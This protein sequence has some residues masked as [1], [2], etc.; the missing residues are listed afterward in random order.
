MAGNKHHIRPT[1]GHACRHRTHADLRHELDADTRL[2]VSIAEVEDEL[3]QILDGINIM[4]RRRRNKRNTRRRVTHARDFLIHLTAGKLATLTGLCPLRHL[5]LQLARIRQILRRHPETPGGNLLD[6]RARVVPILSNRVARGVLTALAAV[7]HSPDAVHGDSNHLVRLAGNGTETHGPGNETAHDALLAL[8][9]IQGDGFGL[10][11]AEEPAQRA[12]RLRTLVHHLGKDLELRVIPVAQGLLEL[13]NDTGC[14][15]MLLPAALPFIQ[16]GIFRC[17]LRIEAQ[18][19]L[20]I[21]PR[22]RLPTD[23]RQPDTTDARC[24]AGEISVHHLITQTDCLEDLRTT[25][26]TQGGNTHLGHRLEQTEVHRFKIIFRCLGSR[27]IFCQ[28][29][30][31]RQ[32]H[33]GAEGQ[34]R[35]HRRG[36]VAQQQGKVH[37]LTRLTRLR[38]HAGTGSHAHLT[39]L[40]VH[41]SHG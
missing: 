39:Q 4:M 37:H 20:L 15:D 23:F 31:L 13:G 14:P 33:Q 9:L 17:K 1:L 22:N 28:L 10:R 16:T 40:S 24:R 7:T 30:L 32:V 27:D 26:G 38:Y 25:I 3:C 36:A 6:S 2:R 41:G 5:D 34:P 8:H 19:L 35:A 11:K 12:Q 18:G 29:T 21:E